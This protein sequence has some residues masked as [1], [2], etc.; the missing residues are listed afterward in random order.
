MAAPTS[1]A[2]TAPKASFD[3]AR[4][5]EHLRKQVALGPRPS[6]TPAIVETRKYLIEQLKASGQT[7]PSSELLAMNRT[8]PGVLM[9][10]LSTVAV[11]LV[12]LDMIWKPGA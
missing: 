11:A 4:A 2:Q 3:G 6:G 5:W 1:E 8:R 12:L 10:A 7:G 9:S